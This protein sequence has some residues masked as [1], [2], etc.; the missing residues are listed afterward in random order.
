MGQKVAMFVHGAP[1][2]QDI[3]PEDI[4]RLSQAR[5]TVDDHEIRGS[6]TASDEIV[7]KSPPRRLALATHVLHRQKNFLAVRSDAERNQQ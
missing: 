7:E 2:D 6:Q 5:R 1:L 3:R 4:E